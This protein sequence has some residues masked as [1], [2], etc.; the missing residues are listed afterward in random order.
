LRI[1]GIPPL[2]IFYSP[3]HK[4]VV[5]RQ[6]KKRKLDTMTIMNL[7]NEP[8]DVVWKDTPVDPLE[9]LTK[10]SQ[11]TRDYATTTINKVTKV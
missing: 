3:T 1:D 7:E 8:M 4:V 5:K 9:N 6:R 10:L 11:F 2:D